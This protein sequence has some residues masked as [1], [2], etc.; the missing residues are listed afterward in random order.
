M[1]GGRRVCGDVCASPSR[2]AV[3]FRLVV[4]M[5]RSVNSSQRCRHSRLERS[6]EKVH[7][8]CV[9]TGAGVGCGDVV[10]VV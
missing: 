10:G 7:T 2:L 9:L 1:S 6:S 8:S 3:V 5:R 4:C